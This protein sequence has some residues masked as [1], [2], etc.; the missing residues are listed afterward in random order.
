MTQS[1]TEKNFKPLTEH[2]RMLTQKIIDIAFSIHKALGPGL[3]ESVYQKC[4]CYELSNRSIF[5]E[6][7]KAVPIYYH[8]LRI[9]DALRLDIL[10]EN[11]VIIELKAQENYH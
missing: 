2:E 10:I 3:L 7:Q 8:D 4:F 9:E 5:F 1:N 6:T 11:T